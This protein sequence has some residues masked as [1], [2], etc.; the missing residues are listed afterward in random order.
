M[1]EFFFLDFI[2]DVGKHITVNYMMAKDSVKSRLTG[3]GAME[4]HL[5]NLHI[6]WFKDMISFTYLKTTI[7]H[8]KWGVV[9]SGEILQLELS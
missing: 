5:L 7:V 2:R 9:I 6:K 4:C 1:K 3:E 8:Y